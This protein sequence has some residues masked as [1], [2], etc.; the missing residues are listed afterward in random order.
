M[1]LAL[2]LGFPAIFATMKNPLVLLS[3]SK[4]MATFPVDAPWV[5]NASVPFPEESKKVIKAVQALSKKRKKELFKVSDAM[6]PG[7]L[8]MWSLKHG[9]F[10]DP[11]MG[12]PGLFAYTGESFKALDAHSLGQ[13]ALQRAK[14]SIAVLSGLYGVV[15]PDHNIMPYRLEMQSKL[16][17]GSNKN[18]YALWKPLLTAWINAHEAPFIV[19]A[20]SGEYSKAVDWRSVQ[21]PVVHVD[22]K[23]MKDGVPK[24]ISAFSKQARGHMARWI[25]QQNVQT[26]FGLASFDK[27]GYRLYSHEGDQMIFLRT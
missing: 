5:G 27:E 19:N 11:A 24:S 18:L 17:T 3:P 25:V 14:N 6:L 20:M 15:T 16:A 10:L 13:N 26:I 9:E 7:V 12:L 2:K 4:G 23:Q 1:P 21:K 8:D 22:F